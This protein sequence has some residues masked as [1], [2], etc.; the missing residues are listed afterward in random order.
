MTVKRNAG[1]KAA[2]TSY[3]A[4]NKWIDINVEAQT[5][6]VRAK[7]DAYLSAVDDLKVASAALDN[8]ASAKMRADGKIAASQYAHFHTGRFGKV[9]FIVND[10]NEKPAAKEAKKSD[11]FTI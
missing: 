4:T 10:L 2:A 8:A 9:S 5:G 6:I 11:D 7:L 1:P 3:L